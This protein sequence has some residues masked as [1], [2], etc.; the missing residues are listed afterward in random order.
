MTRFGGLDDRTGVSRV[1]ENA[2][3]AVTQTLAD[4]PSYKMS[5]KGITW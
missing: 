4:T 5:K 2:M 3:K 1:K